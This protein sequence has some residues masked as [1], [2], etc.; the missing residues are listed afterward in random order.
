MKYQGC[1]ILSGVFVQS[2]NHT[3]VDLI[4]HSGTV[5]Q[6]SLI[7]NSPNKMDSFSRLLGMWDLDANIEV[8]WSEMSLS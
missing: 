8:G 4:I 2:V 6:F 1:F 5:V 3:I 7:K